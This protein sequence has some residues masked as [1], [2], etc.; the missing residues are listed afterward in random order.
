MTKIIFSMLAIV[1]LSSTAVFADGGKK[2][3]AT[4][5]SCDK[6]CPKTKDCSKAAVCPAVPGCVCH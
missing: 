6:G 3:P 1:L 4:I 2:K 5:K